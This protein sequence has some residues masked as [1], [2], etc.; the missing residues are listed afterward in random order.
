MPSAKIVLAL[1]LIGCCCCALLAQAGEYKEKKK[2]HIVHVPKPVYIKKPVYV[3]VEKKVPVIKYKPV[4][5]PK[6]VIVKKIKKVPV[7]KKVHIIQKVKVPVIK[8]VP[9]PVPVKQIKVSGMLLLSL[10]LS[11]SLLRQQ[12]LTARFVNRWSR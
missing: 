11:A 12:P 9:Y 10:S 1:A 5:V 4:F 6:P 7:I 3:H 2:I 8:K